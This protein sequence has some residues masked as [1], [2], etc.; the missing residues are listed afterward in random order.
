[1]CTNTRGC[2][3]WYGDSC[4]SAVGSNPCPPALEPCECKD[5]WSYA[6]T[7]Y[8]GCQ[9]TP[10]YS[11]WCYTTAECTTTYSTSSTFDL[12]GHWT[13]CGE[14]D[15]ILDTP[16]TSDM[17]T[18][19]GISDSDK[20]AF[21]FNNV[22]A[23][24]SGYGKFTGEFN[25]T[26]GQLGAMDVKIAVILNGFSFTAVMETMGETELEGGVQWGGAANV[27]RQ[28]AAAIQAAGGRLFMCANTAA[29]VGFAAE[30]LVEGFEIA[31]YGATVLIAQ[32]QAA[33]TVGYIYIYI[34]IY[35]NILLVP[36]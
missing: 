30:D 1:M 19:F 33:G 29:A 35:I 24:I 21:G 14:P 4:R 13:D 32:L 36:L 10:G 28:R 25:A 12:G 20:V 31:P 22:L 17:Y 5:S 11:P 6:G 34:Y 16:F 8:S 2:E 7:N 3:W 26:V 15:F 18:A 27:V 23:H 9:R